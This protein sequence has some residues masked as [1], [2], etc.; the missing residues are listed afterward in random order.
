ML[1]VASMSFFLITLDC[2]YFDVNPSVMF[3]NQEFP[4]QCESRKGNTLHFAE[5]EG[6]CFANVRAGNQ[7]EKRTPSWK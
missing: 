4:S 5:R 6:G 3:Y 1:D 7:G 2:Q